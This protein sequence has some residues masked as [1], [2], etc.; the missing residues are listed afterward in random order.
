MLG[1][2]RGNPDLALFPLECGAA[3]V[4]TTR[5][6]RRV[7]S[8]SAL[9]SSCSPRCSSSSRC[10][11]VV[12]PPPAARPGASL[13]EVAAGGWSAPSPSYVAATD[14]QLHDELT[15]VPESD[16]FVTACGRHPAGSR[17]LRDGCPAAS[18]WYR[19]LAT[20]CSCSLGVG[21]RLVSRAAGCGRASRGR[22]RDPVAERD[23]DLFW[24]GALRRTWA[25]LA[26]F[27][28]FDYR[29]IFLLLDRAAAGALGARAPRR[30]LRDA[31][32]RCLVALRLDAWADPRLLGSTIAPAGASLDGLGA[33]PRRAGPASLSALLSGPSCRG[34]RGDRL[35]GAQLSRSG[36]HSA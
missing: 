35:H 8:S 30:C 13:V 24:A 10:S 1:V 28:S 19:G 4:V 31:S 3:V 34:C 33:G 20:C 6:S 5:S 29:L 16:F 25:R 26:V 27:M 17:A 15:A 9:C 23:L 2:E 11:T 18:A 32:W 36:Q 21:A 7:R 14:H 12:L 22:A